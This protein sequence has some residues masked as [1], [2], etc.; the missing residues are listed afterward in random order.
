MLSLLRLL[1]LSDDGIGEYVP[2]VPVIPTT[3]PVPVFGWPI[4]S[5]RNAAYTPTFSGGSWR[6]TLPLTNLADR[7]LARLARSTNLLTTSTTFDVDLQVARGVGL[8]ALPKHTMSDGALVRWRGSN[9][10]GSFGSPVYDS[11]WLSAWPL[12]A[13]IEDLDG[14]NVSHVHIPATPQTARYWRCEI[15]NASNP[16]GFV[17]LS[18]V[19]IAGTWYPSTGMSVG[20]KIGLESATER[21]VTDGGAALYRPKP[22]RRL[23]DFTI[24]MLEEMESFAVAWRMMRQLGEHGQLFFVFDTQDPFMHERAFL[25]VI[26]EMSAVEY[27]YAD[28][29]S[30]AFRLVEEL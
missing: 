18:R 30:V 9:A 28:S 27:P 17:D 16:A 24:P 8:L 21:V 7:R 22:I 1:L 20:A 10:E 29:Q 5:D 6:S 25:C 26:R 23:W 2:P 14:M 11:G 3:D 12:G 19:V 13:T 15:D 4:F